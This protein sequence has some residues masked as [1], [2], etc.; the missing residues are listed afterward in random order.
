[1][2]ARDVPQLE[3]FA[4]FLT[5]PD[6]YSSS[7]SSYSGFAQVYHLFLYWTGTVRAVKEHKY[8]QAPPTSDERDCDVSPF[9]GREGNLLSR[10]VGKS[11]VHCYGKTGT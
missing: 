8:V 11:S 2:D 6:H 3:A 9:E 10:E 1:M 7:S 4:F 5:I